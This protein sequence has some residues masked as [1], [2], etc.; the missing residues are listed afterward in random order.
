MDRCHDT[1]HVCIEISSQTSISILS[2]HQTLILAFFI[3]HYTN[4]SAITS[5]HQT[6]R[7]S[8]PITPLLHRNKKGNIFNVEKPVLTIDRNDLRSSIMIELATINHQSA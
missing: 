2:N 3:V 8:H 7:I 1:S 6:P 5:H 4:T